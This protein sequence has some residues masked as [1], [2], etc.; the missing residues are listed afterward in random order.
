VKNY[1]QQCTICQQAKAEHVKILELLSPFPIPIEAWS[2]ISMDFIEGL[3]KFGGFECIFVII[4]KLTKYGHFIPLSHP[5][6]VLTVPQK[7]MDTVYRPPRT[8]HLRSGSHFTSKLWQE[9]FRLSDTKLNMISAHHSQIDGQTKKMNQCLETYLR[10]A[11][12]ASP[13]K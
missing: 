2:T 3:P 5:F 6:I 9:F 8:N 7:Y 10:Y 4:D 12:H 1:V 13:N 11:V